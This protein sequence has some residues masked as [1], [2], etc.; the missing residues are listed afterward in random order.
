MRAVVI[1]HLRHVADHDRLVFLRGRQR[2]RHRRAALH[3][4]LEI[5]LQRV[6]EIPRIERL[7]L[8]IENFALLFHEA[9]HLERVV[10]R[11]S[12]LLGCAVDVERV[13]AALADADL[14]ELHRLLALFRL[15]LL[16]AGDDLVD[17]E[18][19]LDRLIRVGQQLGGHLER[20]VGLDVFG[21]VDADH[22]RLGL[23]LELG[24]AQVR[25]PN[26]ETHRGFELG[27]RVARR[28]VAV[29][30]HD[31]PLVMPGRE[32]SVRQPHRPLQIRPQRALFVTL[33]RRQ[34]PGFVGREVLDSRRFGERHQLQHLLSIRVPL[35]LQP[36][37]R[38]VQHLV[39]H[40]LRH[41]DHEHGR[42]AT[43]RVRD[44][45]RLRQRQGQ[46]QDHRA[47]QR[48]AHQRLHQRR[49]RQRVQSD[50]PEQRDHRRQ[51]QKL[52]GLELVAPGRPPA[53]PYST[54]STAPAP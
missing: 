53:A 29:R 44:L 10:G 42:H 8:Q 32:H 15:D 11:E 6:P 19:A 12:I 43:R 41:V 37:P 4:D 2:G 51:P 17:L 52:R 47:A 49:V 9:L 23:D 40:R 22:H 26:P 30:D 31:Q 14:F 7:A 38:V 54:G 50:Q 46:Q 48:H 45:Q 25:H 1:A 27:Q 13:V 5:V 28:L 39:G 34:L 20:H 16:H 36:K 18:H 33:D 21:H 3:V 35:C 24:Q